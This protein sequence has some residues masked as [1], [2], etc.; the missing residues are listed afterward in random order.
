MVSYLKLKNYDYSGYIFCKNILTLN[1]LF[2]RSD[3][4]ITSLHF[5]FLIN[6]LLQLLFEEFSFCGK[7]IQSNCCNKPL[8]CNAASLKAVK[9][10]GK[11]I[12]H[13]VPQNLERYLSVD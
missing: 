12:K 3:I 7:T 10:D 9:N 4:Y 2:V 11:A 6:S 5:L 8:F 1:K 13:C